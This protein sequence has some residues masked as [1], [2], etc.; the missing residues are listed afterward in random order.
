MIGLDAILYSLLKRHSDN[1]VYPL[2]KILNEFFSEGV[3][4]EQ[5]K[6]SIIKSTYKKEDKTLIDNCRPISILNNISKLFEKPIHN[7]RNMSTTRAIYQTLS[8]IL[9]SINNGKMAMALNIKIT[10]NSLVLLHFN[11]VIAI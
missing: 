7:R 6:T 9:R 2:N 3:F 11:L 1:L 10:C 8:K 4:P 5:L